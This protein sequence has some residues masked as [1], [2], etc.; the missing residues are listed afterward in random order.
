[1]ASFVCERTVEYSLVP[2]LQQSLNEEFT[3]AVPIFFWGNREGSKWA[4]ELHKGRQFRILAFF[5]RRPKSSS[6]AQC[7][8][9]KLNS[10]IC[11]FAK[12]AQLDGIP[13]VV[14]FQA[15][16]HT[17]ELYDTSRRYWFRVPPDTVDGLEFD[18][19]VVTGDFIPYRSSGTRANLMDIRDIATVVRND[20]RIFQW[21][22]GI[23]TIRRLR[24]ESHL[25]VRYAIAEW[26]T[27]G[28]Y[29]PVYFFVEA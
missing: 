17:F 13:T 29:K 11:R 25:G 19:D 28:G 14:G 24:R 26:W 23:E 5:A 21:D 9:G 12:A 15:A 22:E 10:E 8:R 20:T 3:N 16:R 4:A 6:S 1:M 7:V 27:Y 2:A 18:I